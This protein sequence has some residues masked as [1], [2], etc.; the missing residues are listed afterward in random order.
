MSKT[1]K[2]PLDRKSPIQVRC[3]PDFLDQGADRALCDRP[4][5][6][7][8]VGSDARWSPRRGHV[9]PLKNVVLIV[10]RPRVL[11]AGANRGVC[12]SQRGGVWRRVRDRRLAGPYHSRRKRGRS[13]LHCLTDEQQQFWA[14]FLPSLKL[15]DP[16]Q[17]IP[18]P[19]RLG[20]LSF[21]LS[22]PRGSSWLMVYRDLRCQEVGVFLSYHRNTVDEYAMGA[23]AD[24]WEVVKAQLASPVRRRQASRSRWIPR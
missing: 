4:Q 12:G 2:Q 17:P 19:A 3:E 15:D 9:L 6:L 13:R 20:N 5:E 7:L 11:R 22:A 24:Q 8:F 16:E 21:M 14:E 18:K 23:I 10:C 1:Q